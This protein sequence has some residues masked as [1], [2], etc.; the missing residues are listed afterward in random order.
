M[1]RPFQQR[2]GI[3]IQNAL[4]QP[5]VGRAEFAFQLAQQYLGFALALVPGQIRC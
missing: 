4:A 5:R 1:L 2:L 3:G